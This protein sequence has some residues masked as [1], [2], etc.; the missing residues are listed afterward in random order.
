MNEQTQ[1]KEIFFDF[2]GVITLDKQGSP[3]IVAYLS[4]QTHLPYELV[5]RAYIKYNPDMLKGRIT[6]RDM[7]EPF[8]RTLGQD[9]DYALLHDAFLNVSLDPKMLALIR[10]LKKKYR[11]GMI[12]DN[13]ADRIETILEN[14]ALKGLFDDVIISANVGSRKTEDKIFRQAL[15]ESGLRA[16]ECVF[17]D[18]TAANLV[19][20]ADMG[21]HTI[22]FDDEK[23]DFSELLRL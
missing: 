2:D 1:I 7:W 3:T 11:L 21:F 15:K 5:Y 19:V 10:S 14:T 22:F 4:E 17:I 12:T 20:P 23:R 16:G 8:C 13:K 9:V 6:H 18:N